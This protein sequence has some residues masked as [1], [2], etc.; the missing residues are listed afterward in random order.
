[1][2]IRQ[3]KDSGFSLVELMVSLVIFLVGSM[4]LLPLLI[5]NMQVNQGNGLHSQAR[6]LAGE[7]L[8]SLQVVAPAELAATSPLPSLHGTI[9]LQREIET[10]QPQSGLSRITVIA[11]WE[12][13]GRQHSYRLQSIRVTP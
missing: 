12:Q 4:G 8:T 2:I 13:A 9:E 5:T 11:R 1:M 6:R 7:A 10:G 3:A